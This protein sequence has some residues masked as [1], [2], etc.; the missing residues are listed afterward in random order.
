MKATATSLL[1]LLAATGVVA[2]ANPLVSGLVAYWGFDGTAGNHPLATGGTGY[3]GNLIGGASTGGAAKVGTGALL[4]D[5][6]ND[7]MDVTTMAGVNINQAW[8]VSAWYRSDVIYSTLRGMVYE[9]S[10]T[11]SMSFG[12]R[13][14][15]PTTNTAHQVFTDNGPANDV[16]QS[17]QITDAASVNT[18]HHI[19]TVF[20]PA[21]PT[22]AGSIIGYLDGSPQF[23]LVI[24]AGDTL[25]AVDGFHVGT[26]R[27]ATAGT[28]GR[29]FDGTID[30]VAIWNR[31]LSPVE[32]AELH[33]RGQSGYTIV[34]EKITVALSAT[35]A[36]SGSVSGGGVYDPNAAVPVAATP[37]TGYVFVAWDGDFTGRPAEF[38]Y[39]ATANATAAATFARDSRDSD[40]DGLSNYDEL[41]IHQ[42][43]PNDPDTDHDGIPDGMEVNQTGTSPT[44]DDSALVAFVRQNLSPS[45][46]GAI[47]M[48]TPAIERDPSTGAVS[49]R[50]SFH[51][52]ADR[53]A[54]SLISLN[55]PAVTITVDG[56]SLQLTVPAPSAAVDSYIL[57][58]TRP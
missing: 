32:A 17:V 4:L 43:L 50:L 57:L 20:T 38:T 42:T 54:W 46:A 33:S 30:E 29:W 51:G 36:G 5:G 12:L 24:P 9:T 31:G 19:A 2:A 35:P 34:E 25:G 48:G 40:N 28:G 55:D 49:L 52:S 18:W 41:V 13:E 7:Y 27:S 11:Y 53:K 23:N 22:A 3:D 15:T 16:S 1:L 14:G 47:A 26:F 37:N 8:S 45:T 56:T 21:T 44:Q 39:T 10:G 58:G 6:V